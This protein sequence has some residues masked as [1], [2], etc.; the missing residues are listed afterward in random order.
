MTN[1]KNSNQN[2]PDI[3]QTFNQFVDSANQGVKESFASA[4][5]HVKSF[6]L[7]SALGMLTQGP[8][9]FTIPCVAEFYTVKL[10]PFIVTAFYI[11]HYFQQTIHTD[12][13]QES[14]VQASFVVNAATLLGAATIAKVAPPLWNTI[15]ILNS[16]NFFI[17]AA[18]IYGSF[19]LYE[20]GAKDNSLID[21]AITKVSQTLGDKLCHISP[22]NFIADA[23]GDFAAEHLCGDSIVT[24]SII[25]G[26]VSLVGVD[27]FC[28]E[29][30]KEI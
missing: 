18:P 26:F 2:T 27:N 3:L 4:H 12:C 5:S 1:K 28:E 6:L 23:V 8:H 29:Y 9:K 25:D 19:L 7:Y 24:N 20:S 16:F 13:E 14:L 17:A 22:A 21:I 11:S 15:P 10:S 30:S